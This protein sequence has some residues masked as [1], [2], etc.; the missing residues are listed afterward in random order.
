MAERTPSQE[1]LAAIEANKWQ[2]A[3]GISIP[4]NIEPPITVIQNFLKQVNKLLEFSLFV[5][6]FIKAFVTNFLNPLLAIV[7]QIITLLKALLQDIRQIGLYIAHD[8][9]LAVNNSENLEGG[10]PAFE[11]RMVS[12]L[13]DDRD[14]NR[15][16]FS[17]QSAAIAMYFYG[18][19]EVSNYAELKRMFLKIINFFRKTG[20]GNGQ[21]PQ[22]TN[23]RAK[24][25]KV[26]DG[27]FGPVTGSA[28][29]LTWKLATQTKQNG[30][31]I[32]GFLI[33]VSTEA[34]G[35]YLGYK[36]VK[37]G[38][39][40]QQKPS[41]VG[42][43][44]QTGLIRF[45]RSNLKLFGGYQLIE[46]L[47][48]E[49]EDPAE[50]VQLVLVRS[51][52]DNN[53]GDPE[54]LKGNK[55]QRTFFVPTY[56][57]SLDGSKEHRVRILAEDLPQQG[58]FKEDGTIDPNS[59]E[60]ASK[61]YVSVRTVDPEARKRIL[62]EMS[63]TANPFDPKPIPD[64]KI[65]L[66][67]SNRIQPKSITAD[68]FSRSSM[69]EFCVNHE[70]VNVSK[71][72]APVAVSVNS[73]SDDFVRVCFNA[74]ALPILW[75]YDL[76]DSALAIEAPVTMEDQTF[77]PKFNATL[78]KMM[79][80][81]NRE[82][83]GTEDTTNNKKSQQWRMGRNWAKNLS[84]RID[85]TL[86]DC[87]ERMSFPV[88]LQNALI[89][90][91]DQLLVDLVSASGQGNQVGEMEDDNGKLNIRALLRG[92][93]GDNKNAIYG[94]LDEL[95]GD[96]SKRNRKFQEKNAAEVTAVSRLW[97][98]WGEEGGNPDQPEN[99]E[100][101]TSE[102]SEKEKLMPVQLIFDGVPHM[103]T[104]SEIWE[105]DLIRQFGWFGLNPLTKEVE[106]HVITVL[107]LLF[108]GKMAING[109]SDWLAYRLFPTGIPVVE[110]A[111][112]R[113]IDFFESVEENLMA[114]IKRILDAIAVIEEKIKRIQQI[115]DMINRLL[116]LL[117]GFTID[118]EIPLS[119]LCHIANGTDGLVTKLITSN[120]KPETSEPD[121]KTLGMVI[122]AGGIPSMLA[123]LWISFIKEEGEE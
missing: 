74:I 39:S 88:D 109:N 5:L 34:N 29:E 72:C 44:L 61:V 27:A 18:D 122:V 87:F 96:T 75:G 33:E 41:P 90:K 16:N 63:I 10:Y 68:I 107:N 24:N 121:T 123:D 64:P 49:K 98:F 80:T 95:F 105:D 50:G 78:V 20:V 117:K 92:E 99:I 86:E 113:T 76:S 120:E 3:G 6:D 45:L 25:I 114:F 14:P 15:P 106:G 58:V 89:E 19:S 46:D 26:R 108:G 100:F 110:N 38:A 97:Y 32:G 9:G 57:F 30:E 79:E 54:A 116:E 70:E 55:I 102:L 2:S 53:V 48:Y 11:R 69:V 103:S 65:S 51:P 111:I 119:F 85:M 35:F 13:T 115:I 73:I 91:H 84:R 118:L 4:I 37:E 8:I 22:V 56:S 77:L 94:S 66:M 104:S 71:G 52:N 101:Q 23:L 67:W 17:N 40:T 47:P 81:V 83:Y 93:I 31:P 62:K 82:V 7:R 112:K 36:G 59:L 21:M 12:R 28:I 43:Q 42:P 60:N 1:Q